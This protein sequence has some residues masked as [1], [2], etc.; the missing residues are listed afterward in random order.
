[1]PAPSTAPAPTPPP[2]NQQPAELNPV[3]AYF[4]SLQA[5]FGAPAAPAAPAVDEQAFAEARASAAISSMSATEA[6]DYLE[7][8]VPRE[9]GIKASVIAASLAAVRQ[10]AT[11]EAAAMAAEAA[12]RAKAEAVEKRVA[13]EVCLMSPKQAEAYLASPAPLEAGVAPSVVAEALAIVREAIARGPPAPVRQSTPSAAADVSSEDEVSGLAVAAL[14][15]LPLAL[16]GLNGNLEGGLMLPEAPS[17]QR[18][19]PTATLAAPA[20]APAPKGAVKPFP[21]ESA[22]IAFKSKPGREREKPVTAGGAKAPMESSKAD[23]KAK[24]KATA[25]EAKAKAAVEKAAVDAKQAEQKAK[26]KKAAEDVKDKAAEEK[27]AVD[28][29]KAEE[30]AKRKAA[31]DVAKAKAAEEKAATTKAAP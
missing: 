28:A 8:A 4:A 1:V 7:S 13:A 29:K 22:D 24:R 6:L 23:E 21:E 31:A 18:E 20:A 25:N 17:I 2:P 12:A 19:A 9:L 11:A 15:V 14:G 3:E 26:K 27:A 30:R 10:A 16:F 5:K